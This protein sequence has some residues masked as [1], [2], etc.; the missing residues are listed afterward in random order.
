MH[1]AVHVPTEMTH[2]EH[3]QDEPVQVGDHEADQAGCPGAHANGSH[4]LRHDG[5][6]AV[7]SRHHFGLIHPDDDADIQRD[8]GGKDQQQLDAA[9][10]LAPVERSVDH[11]PSP[12]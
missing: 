11:L 12:P 9:L 7:Q 1:K 3:Q 8:D 10:H 6:K 2:G 4:Q 5:V